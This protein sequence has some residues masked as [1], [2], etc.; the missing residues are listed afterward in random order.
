MIMK[1]SCKRLVGVRQLT[2]SGKQEVINMVSLYSFVHLNVIFYLD[3]REH[4]LYN[5]KLDTQPTEREQS[6]YRVSRHWKVIRLTI[7]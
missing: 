2:L 5:H 4:N 1:G 3:I 7:T 6:S